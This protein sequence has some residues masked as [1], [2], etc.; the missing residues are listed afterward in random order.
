MMLQ[1]GFQVYLSIQRVF[2]NGLKWFGPMVPNEFD[3]VRAMEPTSDILSVPHVRNEESKC[4][5]FFR[6]CIF[7][8]QPF[9]LGIL[10]FQVC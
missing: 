7:L 4:C 2:K 9:F 5:S 10:L 1:V 8:L 3:E 6:K